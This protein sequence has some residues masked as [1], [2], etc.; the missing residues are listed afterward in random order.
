MI[1]VGPAE[2]LTLGSSFSLPLR[3]GVGGAEDETA[4]G[5]PT[6]WARSEGDGGGGRLMEKPLRSSE[7][8]KEKTREVRLAT[9][10]GGES[11]VMAM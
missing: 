8:R 6:G 9:K 5:V 2:P 3:L 1:G 4:G 10:E 11:S 7:K